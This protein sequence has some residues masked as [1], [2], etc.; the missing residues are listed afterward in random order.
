MP[1][2]EWGK[3][4]I[5]SNCGTKF[6]D[7]NRKS[8]I[9]PNC[10]T[11]YTE[12]S[13]QEAVSNAKQVFTDNVDNVADDNLVGSDASE[14]IAEVE[15]LEIDEPM[16]NDTISLEETETDDVSVISDDVDDIDIAEDHNQEIE[17]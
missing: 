8:M 15:D 14:S 2:A 7:L 16:D 13:I 10:G 17:E 1:K 4:V 9:C 3:K 11:E 5:C 6:Y 12:P